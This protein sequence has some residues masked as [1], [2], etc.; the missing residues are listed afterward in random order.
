VNFKRKLTLFFAILFALFTLMGLAG[1]PKAISM[2]RVKGD[3]SISYSY[4]CGRFVGIIVWG[5]F[6]YALFRKAKKDVDRIPK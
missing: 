5:V 6:S 2:A 4:L 1:L 3:S